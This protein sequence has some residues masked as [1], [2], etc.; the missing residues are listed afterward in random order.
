MR[1]PLI[2]TILFSSFFVQR[3]SAHALWIET[4]A[5]GKKGQSQEVRIYFGEFSEKDLSVAGKW[6]SDLS[7][8]SLVVVAPDGSRTTLHSAPAGDHY[9][10]AFS[11]SQDGVYTLIAHH[12]VKDVYRNMKLDYNSGATVVVGNTLNG[13][14]PLINN[15]VVSLFSD[16][17]FDIVQNKAL[18]IRAL[19]DGKPAAK[20]EIKV[21]APNG[22]EK[23]LYSNENGE[24]RF[25]PLWPGKYMAE[26]TYTDKTPGEH[27][28]KAYTETRKISTYALWVK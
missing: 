23:G 12:I 2:L 8:F 6:F 18:K 15:N 13:N 20:Q 19:Y 25:T 28:G 9:K 7:N 4:N 17:A 26:F 22:W 16:S 1:L 21:I 10:A 5:T 14:D 27:N 24:A 11:P 3:S